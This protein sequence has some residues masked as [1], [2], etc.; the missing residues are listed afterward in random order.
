MYF[1]T[2][3]LY[4]DISLTLKLQ[5]STMMARLSWRYRI[6]QWYLAYFEAAEI[7]ND[8]SC[9][10]ELHNSS[11]IHHVLWSDRILVIYHVLWNYRIL[12]WYLVYFEATEF[13]NGISC[14][15]KLQN[16]QSNYYL[17]FILANQKYNVESTSQSNQS[18]NRFVG[19][20]SVFWLYEGK[21]T[22]HTNIAS[23]ILIYFFLDISEAAGWMFWLFQS[24][25]MDADI[26]CL[27]ILCLLGAFLNAYACLFWI[28]FI[29]ES[30]VGQFIIHL[31]WPLTRPLTERC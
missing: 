16:S 23:H 8:I 6:S 26:L 10:L 21:A 17:K 2:T 9:T 12:Q 14:T 3:E 1:E 22:Y 15:L 28:I 19:V 29:E 27:A 18:G 13:Y 11:V 25:N 4:N 31:W 30:L 5:N 7:C 24:T 20:F